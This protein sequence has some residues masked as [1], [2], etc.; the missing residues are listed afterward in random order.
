M[1]TVA[2]CAAFAGLDSNETLL[3]VSPSAG[4]HSLLSSYL[5][6]LSRGPAAVRDMIVADLRCWLDLGAP[7]RAADL[8]VV[9]RLFLSDYPQARCSAPA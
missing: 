9:L 8:L 5:L 4:H 2:Q 3:G 1:I 6:N 7:Q